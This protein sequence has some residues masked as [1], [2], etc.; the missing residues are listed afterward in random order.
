MSIQLPVH[1]MNAD[2]DCVHRGTIYGGYLELHSDELLIRD[3]VEKLEFD[4]A[5]LAKYNKPPMPEITRFWIILGD[6]IIDHT[7]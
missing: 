7:I 2:N 5:W 1:Y 3:V 4:R 6:R